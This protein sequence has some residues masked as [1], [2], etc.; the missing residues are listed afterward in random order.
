LLVHNWIKASPFDG[1]LWGLS[2]PVYFSISSGDVLVLDR[3]DEWSR[4]FAPVKDFTTATS[5]FFFFNTK[6]IRE[7]LNKDSKLGTYS[8]IQ[9]LKITPEF[10]SK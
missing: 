10:A 2:I 9:S 3:T 7:I 4:K 5:G 1:T 8:K 6:S